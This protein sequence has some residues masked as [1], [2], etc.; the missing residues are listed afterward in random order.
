[1]PFVDYTYNMVKDTTLLSEEARKRFD[2]VA[3]RLDHYIIA[4][5]GRWWNG[6]GDRD[7]LP[8]NV[9]WMYN[10][11][12]E[13]WSKH[14]TIGTMAPSANHACAAVIDS[15]I[16][17][18]GGGGSTHLP[19]FTN[20]LWKL[21][22]KPN[23]CFEWSKIEILSKAKS[24]SPRELHSGWEYDGK[25]WA[26]GGKGES[27]IGFLNDHGDYDFWLNNQLLCFDPTC[28]EWTNPACSGSVPPPVAAHAA[29]IITD[30]IWQFGGFGS[31]RV[32]VD[33]LYMLNMPSLSWTKI[34]AG[35]PWPNSRS[36]STFTALTYSLLVLH[37]GYNGKN[38]CTMIW[39]LD[40]STLSW[41]ELKSV[42]NLPRTGHT[43]TRDINSNAVVIGGDY[44]LDDDLSY[45]PVENL[46][47]KLE[48]KSL[49]QLAIQTI[50]KNRNELP[51]ETLP[52]KLSSLLD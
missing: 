3:V 28:Q 31:F 24:P 18:F 25:L 5:G 33:D 32:D 43:C 23:A 34:E 1:M 19:T 36:F 49:Q 17:M 13:Q 30:N 11:Y 15:D 20:A 40:L 39:I 16:Y 9:I 38:D 12:T 4:F 27:P 48:A 46:H 35:Y 7:P 52:K 41:K 2:H 42:V 37:G 26:F 45:T 8:L 10:L 29:T 6:Y 50:H 51:L 22:K 14:G 21:V 47:M 44:D